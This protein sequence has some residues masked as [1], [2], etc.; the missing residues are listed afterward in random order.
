MA[1]QQPSKTGVAGESGRMVEDNANV[2]RAIDPLSLYLV[3]FT[4]GAALMG[5]E[6]AGAR[7]VEPHF[8][9]TIYVWGS[10]IGVFML[11]LSVGYWGGGR[12]ADRSPKVETLGIILLV[13][14]L[15]DLAIPGYA[16][17]FCAWLND[18][19][20]IDVRYRTL[21]A[22]LVLFAPPSICMGMVSPFGIRLAASQVSAL[23]SVA[24]SLY[25]ISTLG[26]IVGTFLVSFVLVELI[27]T[28]AI[29]YGVGVVLA[30]IAV[31]CFFKG[32]SVFRK[33]GTVL[34]LIGIGGGYIGAQTPL[35][36][37]P[38]DES[39]LEV[40]ESA[41]H[42][43]TIVDGR[44][45][46]APYRL[47]ARLMMFNN[48]IESGIILEENRWEDAE[49]RIRALTPPPAQ[50]ACGYVDLLHLGLVLSGHAPKDMLILGCGGGVGPRMFK[51]N[52]PDEVASI[53]VVDIDPWVF[54][55]A[56]KWFKYPF[57]SDP[58]IKSHVLDGRMYVEQQPADKKWDYIIMDA[59]SSGGRIP[60][61]LITQEFFTSIRDRLTDDG[62]MVINVISA[63][64]RPRTGIDH[65]RL[66]RSVYKTIESVYGTDQPDGGSLYVFPRTRSGH[67]ENIILIATKS[68]VP[69]YQPRDIQRRYRAI[70]NKYLAHTQLDDVVARQLALRPPTDDVPLLTDD[71]CP[72]DSMVHR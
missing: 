57:S 11:A 20:S 30:L 38:D 69:H 68:G 39:L 23:G 42:F 37:T 70:K 54:K 31:F 49:H 50:T 46:I 7:L 33:V 34:A 55:L 59:Y 51:E 40:K 14:A 45:Q 32:S 6:M 66:F 56:E 15:L 21:L 44:S 24:G 28:S 18:F 48:L 64:E 36:R 5:L 16:P 9:S 8:G 53:D 17:G 4:S 1:K 19:E 52:Y 72:T 13:A 61:H 22:S 25:A 47:P 35:V 26:S 10:I 2:S 27:G 3:V 60:K 43:I 71:F 12:I 65:S 62:I 63:F 29:V 58:V 41:Y 67:G